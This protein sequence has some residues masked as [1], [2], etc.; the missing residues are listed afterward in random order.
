MPDTTT[1]QG[2]S[3]ISYNNEYN[4]QN[5]GED[6]HIYGNFVNDIFYVI[7]RRKVD[8]IGCQK[9]L[10]QD[11]YDI[12]NNKKMYERQLRREKSSSKTR[13]DM[14]RKETFKP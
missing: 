1:Y 5:M 13:S 4:K 6:Q 7:P 3:V 11:F 9:L 12:L 10:I 2:N 14:R 8:G